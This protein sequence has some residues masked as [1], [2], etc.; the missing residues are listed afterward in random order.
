MLHHVFDG[1][2]REPRLLICDEATSALDTAT[3][4]GIMNALTV[5]ASGRTSVFVAHRLVSFASSISAHRHQRQM[6]RC[7][8]L[9]LTE[10]QALTTHT[11][12]HVFLAAC[13]SLQ[14]G[15]RL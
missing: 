8:S 3:E 9:S 1:W 6:R 7:N 2:C 15:C 4:R 14:T 13:G 10:L 12:G 11:D 5:L